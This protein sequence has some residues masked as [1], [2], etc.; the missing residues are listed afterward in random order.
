[1]QHNSFNLYLDI[2]NPIYYFWKEIGVDIKEQSP[3]QINVDAVLAHRVI[4]EYFKKKT[5]IVNKECFN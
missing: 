4:I 5:K 2:I 3:V 1:M